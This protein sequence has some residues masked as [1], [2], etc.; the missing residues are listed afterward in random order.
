MMGLDV[1]SAAQFYLHCK[2]QC[3]NWFPRKK[4]RSLKYFEVYN[5]REKEPRTNR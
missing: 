3:D 4:F 5:V 2:Q 1:L